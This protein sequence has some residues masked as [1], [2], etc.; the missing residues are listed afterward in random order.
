MCRRDPGVLHDDCDDD[1]DVVL[2]VGPTTR[3]NCASLSR[4][5]TYKLAHGTPVA[6]VAPMRTFAAYC[7]LLAF[8]CVATGCGGNANKG[9]LTAKT[10][11]LNR[12]ERGVAE[13][14]L[15]NA[16]RQGDGLPRDRGRAAAHFEWGCEL[17]NADACSSFGLE[18]LERSSNRREQER[19]VRILE[20]ACNAGSAVG[21]ARVGSLLLTGTLLPG[22]PARARS[23]FQ[24]ACDANAELGCYNLG[25]WYASA[26][27]PAQD[28][29][30]AA[31][32]FER[33]CDSMTQKEPRLAARKKLSLRGE[34]GRK[35][36]VGA[37]GAVFVRRRVVV[38]RGDEA[39]GRA[40]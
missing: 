38:R 18:L 13:L 11:R 26:A 35:Q 31:A 23:L 20:N 19:A 4:Y 2:R 32:L 8:A 33:V 27:P 9:A 10:A 5:C 24:R 3:V 21:C 37:A 1:C 29:N 14:L 30:R 22:D 12:Q 40:R 7:L 34:D 28:L 6:P 17:G 16:Y 36:V 39:R 15:G 25:S